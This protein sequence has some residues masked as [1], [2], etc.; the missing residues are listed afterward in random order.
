[1]GS[2]CPAPLTP[3]LSPEGRGITGGR[4]LGPLP[5]ERDYRTKRPYLQGFRSVILV[6]GSTRRYRN[7]RDLPTVRASYRCIGG[8]LAWL[9]RV[10][11]YEVVPTLR[12]L[13]LVAGPRRRRGGRGWRRSV[14]FHIGADPGFGESLDQ[15]ILK[16]DLG[17]HKRQPLVFRLRPVDRYRPLGTEFDE[18]NAPGAVFGTISDRFSDGAIYS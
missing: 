4:L 6:L 5:E 1:M 14:R 9:R 15:G 7:L 2:R 12:A 11:H 8:S 17:C 3:A 13:M 10:D 18:R 16:T